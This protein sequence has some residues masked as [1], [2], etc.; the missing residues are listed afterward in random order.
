MV[1]SYWGNHILTV[2]AFEESLSHDRLMSQPLTEP[3]LVHKLLTVMKNNSHIPFCPTISDDHFPQTA[4]EIFKFLILKTVFL[5]VSLSKF[6][7]VS[8]LSWWY[9]I[10]INTSTHHYSLVVPTTNIYTEHKSDTYDGAAVRRCICYIHQ[11]TEWTEKMVTAALWSRCS[12]QQMHTHTQ[13]QFMAIFASS[14]KSADCPL[15]GLDLERISLQFFQVQTT[16][17]FSSQWAVLVM[18]PYVNIVSRQTS[19]HTCMLCAYNLTPSLPIPLKLYGLPYWSNPPFLFLTF[20]R[21]GAQDWAPE[22]PKVKN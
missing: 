6:S 16:L 13:H 18:D 14:T 2:P 15:R 22:R 3:L 19:G 9:Y 11:L 20:E 5:Y 1:S 7:T 17:I 21:S 10:E 8:N 4:K 12:T